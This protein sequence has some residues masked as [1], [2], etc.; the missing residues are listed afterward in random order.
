MQAITDLRALDA[1]EA[2]DARRDAALFCLQCA[3]S[4][5]PVRLPP[6]ERA[7]LF[8][9]VCAELRGARGCAW[10]RRHRYA[11]ALAI[12]LDDGEWEAGA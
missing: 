6:P 8:A 11:E 9:A 3:V 5:G 2:L 1:R 7:R 4:G 10:E 12:D